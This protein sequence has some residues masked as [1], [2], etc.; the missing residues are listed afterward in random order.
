MCILYP[1]LLAGV[2]LK[3]K[4]MKSLSLYRSS[5]KDH[6]SRHSKLCTTLY[7][8]SDRELQ[9]TVTEIL[10]YGTWS[11]GVQ[12]E[13]Q[14]ISQGSQVDIYYTADIVKES[15]VII[16]DYKRL[17]YIASQLAKRETGWT[18]WFGN[19]IFRRAATLRQINNA[20]E[21]MITRIAG[22]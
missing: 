13:W 10:K 17:W 18:W 8:L 2:T 3:N 16:R 4:N 22:I 15:V 7:F 21:E 9:Y 5:N 1:G 12:D 6:T 20:K 11:E 19:K 14:L